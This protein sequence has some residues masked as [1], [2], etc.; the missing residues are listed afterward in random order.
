MPSDGSRNINWRT[1]SNIRFGQD[2][3]ITMTLFIG[4]DGLQRPGLNW[5]SL[6]INWLICI[7]IDICSFSFHFDQT[8]IFVNGMEF[9]N[10]KFNALPLPG[11]WLLCA[12]SFQ[13]NYLKQSDNKRTTLANNSRTKRPILSLP[14]QWE[15]EASGICC[16][17]SRLVPL[18]S[19]SIESVL[20][21]NR[22]IFGFV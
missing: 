9:Q 4:N 16:L 18:C 20:T 14:V 21:G 15:R 2:L 12:N 10:F 19:S 17:F 22:S 13:L 8:R 11:V 6:I 5:M 1:C 7:I 3:M